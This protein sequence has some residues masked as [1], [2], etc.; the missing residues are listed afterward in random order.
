MSAKPAICIVGLGY[1][2]LPLAHAFAAKGYVTSGFD[3]SAHR[4]KELQEGKDS[5]GELTPAQLA[6]VDLPVSTDPT[7]IASAD[8]VIVALPTPIDEAKKARPEH[9]EVRNRNSGETHETRC[10]HCL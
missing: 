7:I 1:V 4:V 6:E 2:G 10:R 8:V 5:T 9:L 3:I